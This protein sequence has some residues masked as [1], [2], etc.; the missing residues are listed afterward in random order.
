MQT[1]DFTSTPWFVVTDFRLFRVLA[2]VYTLVD[3]SCM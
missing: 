1:S 2:Y 3:V